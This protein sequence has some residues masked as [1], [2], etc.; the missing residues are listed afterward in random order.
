MRQIE[1]LNDKIDAE[2]TER[3]QISMDKKGTETQLND[4]INAC[5]KQF[6]QLLQAEQRIKALED[7]L[8]QIKEENDEMSIQN[9]GLKTK[10]SESRRQINDKVETKKQMQDKFTQTSMPVNRTISVET[11][12]AELEAQLADVNFERN[13]LHEIVTGKYGFR[14]LEA[15]VTGI[16][17][18]IY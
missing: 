9:L 16:S 3:K 1:E 2:A 5:Q 6:D 14:A 8:S 15:T 12:I 11:K 17:A 4:R 18:M 10:L 7:E 13:R